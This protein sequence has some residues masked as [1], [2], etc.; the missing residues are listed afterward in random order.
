M[1][2][3]KPKHGDM[4]MWMICVALKGQHELIDAMEKNEDGSYP[5]IFSVG[6]IKLDFSAVAKRIDE[7]ISSMV[8]EKAKELLDKKYEDLIGEIFD[9]QE[10]IKYQKEKLFKYDWEQTEANKNI[11]FLALSTRV[12]N[13]LFRAKI[14]T[15]GELCNKTYYD[16]RKLKGMGKV[17][18]NELTE[19]MEKHNLYFKEG[20]Q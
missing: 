15:I 8:E 2:N 4:E 5:V 13:A 18:M 12:K 20:E 11:D 17:S 6:G 10:R 16:I 9:I 7:Q 19:I 1:I 14:N 3:Y